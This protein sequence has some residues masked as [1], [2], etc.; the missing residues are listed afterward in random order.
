MERKLNIVTRFFLLLD[1]HINLAKL[2]QTYNTANLS[3]GEHTHLGNDVNIEI[4]K[5]GNHIVIGNSCEILKGVFIFSNGGDISI[6]NNCSIN[7]YCII[8]GFGK[9]TIGNNV[10]IAGATMIIPTNH[11]YEDLEKNINDQ[12]LISKGIT[13]EDDVWIGHGCTILDGV[14]IGR[15]A[16]IAAGSVV[17]KSVEE[18]SIVGGIPA[19]LIK[20]RKAHS[21]LNSL[22]E[23]K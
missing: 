18:Y 5:P 11:K 20:N 22:T 2:K 23:N 14:H 12:G 13:I 9:T 3:I 16:I 6:G 10:L 21:E 19:K 8:Y 1:K 15:G 7:P 4:K 17:T